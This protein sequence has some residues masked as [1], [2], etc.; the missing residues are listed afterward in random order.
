MI[1]RII[2]SFFLILTFSNCSKED[3]IYTPS[4]RIDPYIIYNEGLEAF[5]KND[6]FFA[7]KKFSEAELNFKSIEFAAKSSIMTSFSLYRI[8]FY[9]E[10]IE[11]LENFINKYPSDKNIIYAHFL[12]A[13]IYFEQIEDEKK[14]LKPLREANNKINFFLKNFPESDYALDLKFKKNLI[15]NQLAA[16]E[17]YIAK[18]Y[19]NVQKWVPAISRLKVILDKYDQTVYV[20][21]ALHRLVEIN[22]HLGLEEEAKNYAKILGYNYNSSEWYKQSYKVL[23]K[24]YKIEEIVKKNDN[25]KLKEKSLFNRIIKIIN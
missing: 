1:L 5:K 4:K 13:I 20:E 24:E 22:Y 11:N 3:K 6:F 2:I 21:E 18:Y 19:I 17:M 10:A 16:K 25:K 15:L 9:N 12:T 8:N 23:N 14:D 7:S